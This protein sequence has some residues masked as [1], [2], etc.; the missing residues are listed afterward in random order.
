MRRDVLFTRRRSRE[1][2]NVFACFAIRVDTL[3]DARIIERE[4]LNVENQCRTIFVQERF[5]LHVPRDDL[6][7]LVVPF[8]L[9]GID[10]LRGVVAYC[11]G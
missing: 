2:S 7:V 5:S 3:E 11:T 8:D 1:D 10:P 9:R 6:V 4:M